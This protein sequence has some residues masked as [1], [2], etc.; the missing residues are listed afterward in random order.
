VKALRLSPVRV[1]RDRLPRYRLV[2]GRCKRCNRRH[3]PPRPRCPYC[4]GDVEHIELPKTG[5]LE[6]FTVVYQV[7]E[8]DRDKS[9]LYVG[10]VRLDDGT[11]VVGQLTDII[12]PSQLK[13]GLRVEAVFRRVAV[14]G[15]YG[16]IAYGVKF[17]PLLGGGSG[18][19]K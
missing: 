9:P 6:S 13:P 17:R 2:G 5:T 8:D 14:D 11:R 15:D 19:G 12:D 1:W 16:V 4:G 3:Y 18:A 7:A 10:L